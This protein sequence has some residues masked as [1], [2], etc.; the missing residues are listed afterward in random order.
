MADAV[1]ELER[2]RE[3]YAGQAWRG[4]YESLSVADRADPLGPEDLEL[5]ATSAYML[6]R[7]DEYLALLERAHSAHLK[8]DEPARAVRC[9]FWVGTHFAQRGEMAQAGG[10]LGRAQRLLERHGPLEVERG[11]LLLPSMFEQLG[12]GLPEVA[13]EIA[14]EAVAI[15]ESCGDRELFALAA[16]M[17][18]HIRI[19]LGRLKDGMALLDE[20]MLPAAAGE[21]SPIV[22]GIVYCGV[23]LA[24]QDAH[25]VGR[26]REWTGV[27]STWCEDQPDLVSFT[28]R[29]R[30][31]R[32]EI[33]QLGGSWSDALDEARR[34]HDRCLEG[35]NESA[36][37]EASY[38]QAE[39]HRL[40]GEHTAA[41][42]AYREA[43]GRG[44]E[45]QPGLALLRQAQGEG[46]AAV[47]AIRRALAETGE[48]GKRLALLPAC[49]EIMLAAGHLDDARAASVELEGL[50]RDEESPA[51]VATLAL[52]QGAVDLAGGDSGSALPALR[53]AAR[54]WDELE[55]PYEVARARE[56]TG[57]ACRKLGDEEGAALE[58]GAARQSYAGLRAAPDL[59]RLDAMR[60][61]VPGARADRP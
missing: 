39:I 47:A 27:L 38:R 55:A 46:E 15:A 13:A 5:L 28:G 14:G 21:L 37:G 9:A 30:I 43:S 7:E 32:A 53:R 2:G 20:A 45:P 60:A 25:E 1:T 26:A 11:Y 6:G 18:G 12:Q 8:A 34:A 33:M 24:C 29:C 56:L 19:E 10:W 36:A 23:I 48:P 58:L 3:R 41:D 52:A 51:L 49:V 22:T 17:Q 54:I 42:R 59:V 16:H 44:R 31:H 40:R 50:M 57:H 61:R 4:A 35:Q